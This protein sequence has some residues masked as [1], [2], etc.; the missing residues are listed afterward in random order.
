MSKP[1]HLRR[2][3]A[4]SSMAQHLGESEAAV[5]AALGRLARF[6]AELPEARTQAQLAA[7]FAHNVYAELAESYHMM[8]SS[9]G[10]LVAAHAL[11]DKAREDLNLPPVLSMPGADKP[12]GLAVAPL[13][14]VAA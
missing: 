14:I 2:L 12:S 7:P 4:A 9:R 1:R 13:A 11:L 3:S 6:L 5:D 10:R 8:V